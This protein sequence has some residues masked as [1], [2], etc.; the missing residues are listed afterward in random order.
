MQDEKRLSRPGSSRAVSRHGCR[1]FAGLLGLVFLIDLIRPA[2]YAQVLEAGAGKSSQA[3]A[4]EEQVGPA[5][6]KAGGELSGAN[7]RLDLGAEVRKVLP[8]PWFLAADAWGEHESRE[9]FNLR[10]WGGDLGVGRELD[11]ATDLLLRY[12]YDSDKV[13]GTGASGDPDF[14]SLAGRTQVT[15]LGVLLRHD[16]RD[17]PWYPTRGRRWKLGGELAS[18]AFGGDY[19]FGRLQGEASWYWTPWRDRPV[20]PFLQEVT[21]V[22]H[23]RGGWAEDFSETEEVPFFERY[24]VGGSSTVR[25]YPGRWLTPRGGEN[26]LVGGEILLVN[27]VE[28]R[29]PVLPDRF[30]R[31]LSAALFFDVGRAF[32]RFSDVGDFGYGAGAG[33]RY[34]VHFW[35]VHG[36]ARA[37]YGFG[38]ERENPGTGELHFTFGSVF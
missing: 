16:E 9:P 27:N 34:V 17:D 3:V 8:A 1:G 25:G 5:R 38:L 29:V 26:E 36:V 32:R 18:K 22:E 31:R 15:A 35:K 21:L 33:L 4:V 24:F 20:S 28:A 7:Q 12:R 19:H 13:Y 6:L 2:C 30:R 14:N 11:A 10:R 23:V 37:D